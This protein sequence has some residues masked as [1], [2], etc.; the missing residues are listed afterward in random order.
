ME[1]SI[2]KPIS[3]FHVMA[4]PTGARCNLNCDYCFFLK[5]TDL[6]PN[7]SFC[8]SDETME[9]Y[10]KQTIETQNT[11]EITIAWQGGEPTLMGLDFFRRVVAVEK[12]YAAKETVIVNTLQTNGVL[13]DDEWCQFLHEN[14]FLIGLSL[15]GP[16]HLHDKFRHDKAGNSVFDQVIRALRLMQKHK[17]EFNILCTINS[18][19]SKHPLEVYK[20]FRDE[21]DA[22]YFQF[23]PIVELDE[24]KKVTSRTVDAKQYGKFLIQIFDE[25]VKK[26]VGETFVQFFDGVL[27]SYIRGFS[28]LCVLQ[29]TCGQGAALEHNGDLYSCDHFVE[30]SYLLGNI[31]QLN[32]VDLISSD[33]QRSFGKE[34]Q[35]SLSKHCQS[36]K[37]HFTCHG[38]CP[39][40]RILKTSD[41]EENL[42]WLCAGLKAFFEHTHKHMQTLSN[43]LQTGR[44][45]SDIMKTMTTEKNGQSKKIGRNEP[46]YCGSGLKYKKCHALQKD[47]S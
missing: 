28:S 17:V 18:E 29:P 7:S 13:L 9:A 1:Q 3:T 41:G 37:F 20:F 35:T 34:K 33:Q 43:L 21:C 42:N 36:C 38:E 31:H 45:A 22:H 16:K 15:D 32:I 40:N 8:M 27:M 47:S 4:K 23:I 46:C 14:N 24:N 5:K 39:K 11:P 10:I 6:Y 2:N 44:P 19:N 26:D 25:W 12:K 30:P